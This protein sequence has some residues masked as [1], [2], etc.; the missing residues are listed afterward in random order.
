MGTRLRPAVVVRRIPDV[1]P[2]LL[3]GSFTWTLGA[4]ATQLPSLVGHL[5]YGAATALV[6]IALERGYQ[7]WLTLDPRIA[8]REA[9]RLRAA[10]TAAP[11]VWLVAL[12]LGVALPI[13]LV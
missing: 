9:R 7:I 12:G 11:A 8:A 6:F 5:L 13:L 10:G 3:G 1:V 4:S 2:I